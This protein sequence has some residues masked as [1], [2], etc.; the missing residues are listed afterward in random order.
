VLLYVA[1]ESKV[2]KEFSQVRDLA[3]RI[4]AKFD[5][6]SSADELLHDVEILRAA[7]EALKRTLPSGTPV[8]NFPRHLAFLER[9]LKQGQL[10]P[11]RG[12]IDDICRLDLPALERAFDAWRDAE[13]HYDPEFVEKVGRLLEEQ[14]LDSAVRKAFVLLKERL[15]RSFGMPTSLDGV[16][17]V[18]AAFGAKGRLAGKIPDSEREAMRDLLAGLYGIFRNQYGH[19]DV[20]PAW[21]EVEAVLAMVNWALRSIDEYSSTVGSA[22]TT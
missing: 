12:D 11:C 5:A 22:A 18:N 14:H 2:Q 7:F 13:H 6:N 16:A 21:F 4:R 8:G 10:D 20:D 1:Y 17:L 9:W 19:R 15:T 3:E